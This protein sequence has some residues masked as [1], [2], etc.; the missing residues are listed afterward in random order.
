MYLAPISSQTLRRL[1]K[2]LLKTFIHILFIRKFRFSEDSVA[3]AF[4]VL[5]RFLR[6]ATAHRAPRAPSA[7]DDLLCVPYRAAPPALTEHVVQPVPE[8]GAGRRARL[9]GA[10]AYPQIRSFRS[11]GM[12][13]AGSVPADRP[14][15]GRRFSV[16]AGAPS[17]CRGFRACRDPQALVS[18]AF[19]PRPQSPWCS[20]PD[21]GRRPALLQGDFATHSVAASDSPFSACLSVFSVV[22]MWGLS[23]HLFYL[24]CLLFFPASRDKFP[25]PYPAAI[26]ATFH[27]C[28]DLFC[29][30]LWFNLFCFQGLIFS[31]LSVFLIPSCFCFGLQRLPDPCGCE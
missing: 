4:S 5:D 15:P 3:R 1:S 2:S 19:T 23:V 12:E 8:Q 14:E 31:P 17:G 30:H 16:S 24:S 26:T 28:F 11:G 25:P 22:R 9:S 18:G 6:P 13:N 7:S 29:F 21:P 27:F 20:R 10:P